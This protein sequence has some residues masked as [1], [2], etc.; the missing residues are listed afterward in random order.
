[1]HLPLCAC[2]LS[3]NQLYY[4]QESLNCGHG[5]TDEGFVEK[6]KESAAAD[7]PADEDEA[8]A[9]DEDDKSVAGDEA[10][11][12]TSLFHKIMSLCMSGV[13]YILHRYPISALIKNFSKIALTWLLW[14]AYEN[15]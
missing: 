12:K 14:M 1:M 3:S 6:L 8:G 7:K 13:L 10:C 4:A 11:F 15:I 2:G 5:G 9:D